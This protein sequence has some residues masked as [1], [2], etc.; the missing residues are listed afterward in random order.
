MDVLEYQTNKN[1][2]DELLKYIYSEIGSATCNKEKIISLIKEQKRASKANSKEY[3][4][5][6]FESSMNFLKVEQEK[7]KHLKELIDLEIDA[8]RVIKKIIFCV[9]AYDILNISYKKVSMF[10]EISYDNFYVI[11]NKYRKIYK[12][13]LVF[14]DMYTKFAKKHFKK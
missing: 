7:L 10:L 2:S 14:T 11:L 9:I 12:K 5:Q 1:Y 6:S 4:M 3:S 13:D 8:K